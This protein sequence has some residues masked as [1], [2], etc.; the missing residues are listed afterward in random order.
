MMIG[1]DAHPAEDDFE[2]GLQDMHGA[3]DP[4]MG[5]IGECHCGAARLAALQCVVRPA[6]LL[7]ATRCDLPYSSLTCCHRL[8]HGWRGVGHA[9][10][11]APHAERP[12]HL[13]RAHAGAVLC[14]TSGTM[15]NCSN[16]N[17]TM[18]TTAARHATKALTNVLKGLIDEQ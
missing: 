3:G 9:G 17:N 2:H 8:W 6:C 7:A 1:R 4:G 16:E 13:P 14:S 10:G 12:A 18:K 15:S 5:L 11:A